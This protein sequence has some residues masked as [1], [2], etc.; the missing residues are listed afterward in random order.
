MRAKV[1]Q[2]F[3]LVELLVVIAIIGILAGL[4]LPAIQVVREQAR[5]AQCTNNLRSLAQAAIA[6]ETSR[7]E[8]PGYMQSFG[9]FGGGIGG[10]GGIDPGD[11]SGAGG[12]GHVKVGTWAVALMPNLDSQPIYELWSDDQYPVVVEASHPKI[13]NQNENIYNQ[14]AVPNLEFM[15]CP[16]DI[17]NDQERFGANSYVSNNGFYPG[18]D[19]DTPPALRGASFPPPPVLDKSFAVGNG[20]FNN[21]YDGKGGPASLITGGAV[22]NDQMRDSKTQTVL[23]SENLQALPWY[24][25]GAME[26]TSNV[27][28]QELVDGF[29]AGAESAARSLT[30]MVWAYFDDQQATSPGKEKPPVPPAVVR[31]NGADPGGVD[32]FNLFMTDLAPPDRW[33]L[34]RPSSAHSGGAVMSFADGS[35][36]FVDENIAYYVYQA[37]LTPHGTRSEVPFTKRRISDDDF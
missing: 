32:K 33:Q 37:L 25:A 28:G 23:F 2:G 14:T 27:I 21:K 30:G 12:P 17:M 3:T 26:P 11:P 34:A 22:R 15:I 18:P 5:R 36:R 10:S 8:F 29:P 7:G 6:Y 13:V 4:A 9:T 35:T 31:I 24:R 19:L 20:V 1:R 16:S